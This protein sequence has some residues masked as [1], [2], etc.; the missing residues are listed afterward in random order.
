[1]WWPWEASKNTH[2]KKKKKKKKYS[3]FISKINMHQ[4]VS[5]VKLNS[6]ELLH[7]KPNAKAK[8]YVPKSIALFLSSNSNAKYEF[9]CYCD[10][11]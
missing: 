6:L 5:I 10:Q 4:V 11:N 8:G 1:M 7:P 9:F 2:A 3:K